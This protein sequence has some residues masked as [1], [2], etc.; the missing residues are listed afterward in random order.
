MLGSGCRGAAAG[1]R[2]Y[3]YVATEVPQRATAAQEAAEP[4]GQDV[5]Q[6]PRSMPIVLLLRVTP[7][8]EERQD[9]TRDCAC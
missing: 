4:V 1:E 8:T 9:P 7:P 3:Q 6:F 2:I 5:G